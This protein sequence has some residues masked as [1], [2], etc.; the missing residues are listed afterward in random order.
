MEQPRS[1]ASLAQTLENLKEFS[2]EHIYISIKDLSIVPDIQMNRRNRDLRY[3]DYGLRTTDGTKIRTG[4]R[5][6]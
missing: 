4:T 2:Y 3:D 1:T 6:E 5:H